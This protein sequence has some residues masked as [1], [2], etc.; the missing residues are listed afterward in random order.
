MPWAAQAHIPYLEH[1]G[2]APRI[3][4]ATVSAWTLP[5]SADRS[6]SP[7]RH[8]DTRRPRRRSLGRR[9]GTARHDLN[10]HVQI[11]DVA[12]FCCRTQVPRANAGNSIARMAATSDRPIHDART[13]PRFFAADSNSPHG[14]APTKPA[15]AMNTSSGRHESTAI[16][17]SSY[18][19]GSW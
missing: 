4:P 16:N 18:G 6:V 17:S 15:A 12:V 3:H 11:N 8:H 2:R 10:H 7:P 5:R 1:V 13:Q 9:G 19:L 14:S